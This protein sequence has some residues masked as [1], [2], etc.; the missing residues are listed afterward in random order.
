MRGVVAVAAIALATGCGTRGALP[1]AEASE[2]I[3]FV[4]AGITERAEILVRLGEPYGSFEEGRIVLYGVSWKDQ[5]RWSA[6]GGPGPFQLVIVF[7]SDGIV[8]RYSVVRVGTTSK[9]VP[10]PVE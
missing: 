6:Y 10:E 5:I 3:P 4:R 9:T 1:K 2:I 8:A 7:G